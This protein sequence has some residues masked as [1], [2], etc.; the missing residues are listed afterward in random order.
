[1]RLQKYLISALFLLLLSVSNV[2]AETS[3]KNTFGSWSIM[4]G[5]KNCAMTQLVTKDKAGK[6]VLLGVSINYAFNSEFGSLM[7]RLPANINQEA[8]LGIK[9]DGQKPIRVPIS[10]CTLSACQSV[11]RIDDI[12]LNEL[13]Q[14][15]TALFAFASRSKKQLTLPVSLAKFSEAYAELKSQQTALSLLF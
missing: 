12:L 7:V 4:C 8:G 9:I 3:L 10:Q 6:K 5:E 11:I 13:T 14:G 1:M 15:K 2:F